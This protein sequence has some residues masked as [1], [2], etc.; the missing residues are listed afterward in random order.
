MSLPVVSAV[1]VVSSLFG[2][3]GAAVARRLPPRQ[4]TWLLS[5]GGV[6]AALSGFVVLVLLASLLVGEQ[7][8]VASHGHWSAAALRDR[9]PVGAAS[10]W[11][12]ALLVALLTAGAGTV[13]VRRSRAVLGAYRSCR[14]L[15]AE[16]GELVVVPGTAVGAYA[17]PGR[18]GRIVAGQGLLGALSALERRALLAHERAHLARGH[19]WHLAAVTIAAALHPALRPLRPAASCATERWADE[20]AAEA[21][22]DRRAV[23]HALAAAARC[24]TA[25]ARGALAATSHF[26][27]L[28]VAS[29]LGPVPGPRPVLLRLSIALLLAAAAAALVAVKQTEHLYEF[30]RYG[31]R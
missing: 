29:L 22:G 6:V 18:P 9:A 4:A 13:A 1:L 15:P 8:D 26:V 5:V 11:A 19:H 14:G 12:A 27:P 31:Q 20:S 28:R 16:A 2:F 10:S 17:V 3:W 30:A 21:I 24:S 23:A 7:P 25:P